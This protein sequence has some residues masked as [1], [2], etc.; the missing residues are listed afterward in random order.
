MTPSQEADSNSPRIAIVGGGIGGLSAAAFLHR[1]GMNVTVFEQAPALGEVGAGLIVSPNSVRLIRRLGHFDEFLSK[2][3]RLKIGWEFRRWENGKV[4]FSQK[5][6]DYSQR[7]YNEDSYSAHRADLLEAIGSAVP[8]RLIR[9]DSRCVNVIGLNNGARLEFA[10]G[11]TAEADIVIGADGIH[12]VVRRAIFGQES[13]EYSGMCAFRAVVPAEKA[14]AFARRPTQTLWLGPDHHLVHYPMSGG[15]AINLV[16]FAPAGEFTTESWTS[17]STTAQ[18][19]AEF[20]G[21]DPRLTDLISAAQTPGRWA[22]LDRAPLE[23]WSYGPITLLGDAAHPMFPFF[24]QGSAQAIED[25][26]ALAVCLAEDP[27]APELALQKYETLRIGRTTK[28]QEL[29][30]ARKDINHLA[31]GPEQQARDAA[32]V[33]VDPLKHNGWLYSYDAELAAREAFV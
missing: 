33:G 21:W 2:A 10:D 29:S 5:F 32:F 8:D 31:D 14:P 20:E 23:K 19:L 16:A 1:A 13:V 9:L 30:H 12:S 4:L 15:T 11:S 25:A 7:L 6:G 17:T 26:A 28:I 22:L 27:G 18:L 3:V 24:A